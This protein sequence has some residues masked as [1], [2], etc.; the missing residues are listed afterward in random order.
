MGVGNALEGE[1]Q[2]GPA[3]C[4]RRAPAS[5]PAGSGDGDPDPAPAPDPSG[6]ADWRGLA[7]LH[8]ECLP[9]SAVAALGARY[10]ECF[11]RYVAGS[12]SEHVFLHREDGGAVDAACIVSLDPGS[13]KRRLWRSTPLL[14]HLLRDAAAGGRWKAARTLWPSPRAERYEGEDASP[15]LTG[16]PE[17]ILVF[18]APARRRRG[19]GRALL[20]RARAWLRASGHRRCLARTLDDPGNRAA[21]FYRAV[22]FDRCGRPHGRGVQVWERGV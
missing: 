21:D 1:A 20:A 4:G 19:L 15:G 5:C 14:R 18:V 3:P 9:S 7:V 17:I 10:T 2:H 13:L 22:G 11:Y 8:R 12:A 16:A 6:A